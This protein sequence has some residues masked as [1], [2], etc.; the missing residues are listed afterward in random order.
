MK[1]KSPLLF[2]FVAA[3]IVV[4]ASAGSAYFFYTK[5]AHA[6]RLLAN[7]T[8][9]AKLEVTEVTGKIGRLM[10]LPGDEEP[11]IATVLDK[12]KVKDQ[13][14]FARAENGDKVVIYPKALKAILYRPSTNKVIE[15]AP[16]SIGEPE[17]L[18]TESATE[19]AVP[20]STPQPTATDTPE[21][22]ITEEPQE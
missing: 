19:S 15:V 20:S 6:Q 4:I 3:G 8:E 1:I 18:E 22:E 14:F 13:P 5:Y 9:A 2:A 21:P 10:E 7:P 12:E 16:V 11:T 17:G